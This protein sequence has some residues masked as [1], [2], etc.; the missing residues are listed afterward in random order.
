MTMGISE[1]LANLSANKESLN[2]K[3]KV[4]VQET[5][6]AEDGFLI[7]LALCTPSATFA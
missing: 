2:H 1:L 6:Q 7:V 3:D 4:D 5:E